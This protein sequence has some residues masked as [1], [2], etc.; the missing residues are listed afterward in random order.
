MRLENKNRQALLRRANVNY[1]LSFFAACLSI[2]LISATQTTAQKLVGRA[3]LGADTF[4]PGPTSGQFITPSNGRTPPFIE[5]QPVQ[6]FSAVLRAPEGDFYVLSDNGFGSKANSPD[7]VLRVY[8][9]A[10]NF[11]TASVGTGDV[12]VKSFFTLRDPNRKIRFPL[13]A[14]RANY[15]NSSIAVDSRIRQERLLT[16]SDFDVESFRQ[17]ADGTFWFGDEFGPYLLHTDATGKVLERPYALPGVISPDNTSTG[18]LVDANLPRSRGF[19]GMALTPDGTKLYPMLEGSLITDSDQR[20]LLINEFDLT[21]KSYTG[22]R[23]S[24][25]LEA[26]TGSGQA[27]GDFTAI[28]DRRFLVIERDSGEGAAARFKKI[29]LVNLDQKDADGY[30]VKREVVNLLNIADPDD[31]GATGTGVFTFPF[32]TIESVIPLSSNTI[33]VLNDNNYPFSSGRTPSQPDNNEFIIIQLN[34]PLGAP[35]VIGHRGASGYRPEHTLA[36]YEL[37]IEMGAD[38]V[39]PDIVATRDGVLIARHENDVSGTTDVADHPEFANRRITKSIDG[40]AVR[41]WFTEDFTLAELKTLRARERIPQ[42]RPQNTVYDNLCSIPTLQEVIDLVKRKEVQQ[43][44]RIGIYPETKHPSYFD[45]IGKSLEEPLV[46]I[47]RRNGYESFDAPVF[48]QSFEVSNLKDLRRLTQLPLIQLIND[49]G[50][51]FDFVLSND[52]RTY[53]DLITPAGLAEIATYAIGIGANKNLIVP[54]DAANRL[55]PPTTLIS[56]AHARN[57]VV[58]GWTFRRENF[59]LPQELRLGDATDPAYLRLYG[60]APAEF[61]LFYSL[62]IDGVFTDNPDIAPRD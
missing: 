61:R 26:T 35:L 19:E 47:L 42:L 39:E 20:R 8:R 21:T 30:L 51:P 49:T 9:I 14:D 12:I 37:A 7:Y 17:T 57:L 50:K 41:G 29:F 56:D 60:D 3:V 31:I 15:P 46:E 6:G 54:R 45:S 55:L 16:G 2:L 22:N 48:I 5:R 62:G 33:G 25:R 32:T 24:Y 44:R 53:A 11:K 36:A 10:P 34:E 13:I 28:G 4:A 52:S 23:W 1:S 58:H 59:F 18:G 27:I 38:F 43:R 40:V